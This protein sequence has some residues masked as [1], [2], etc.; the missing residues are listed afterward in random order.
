MVSIP[1]SSPKADT[2]KVKEALE[3]EV[4]NGQVEVETRGKKVVI[5]IK[6]NGSFPSGS[7][8]LRDEFLPIMDKMRAVVRE[9]PGKFF[10]EGHTDDIPINTHRFRSNWELSSGRAVSVAH[11]LFKDGAIDQKRFLE[12]S[13]SLQGLGV[14]QLFKCKSAEGRR[15]GSSNWAS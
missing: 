11:E 10:I 13:S 6:E 3:N 7:A 15:A 14:R 12:E 4:K 8:T 2:E 9:M 1:K 5:R